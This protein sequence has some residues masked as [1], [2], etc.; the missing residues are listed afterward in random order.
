M[1]KNLVIGFGSD[2][3]S[4]RRII[5]KLIKDV[6]I[7][8]ADSVDFTCE[9]IN[10]LDLINLF[11][12]YNNLLIIDSV[13]NPDLEIGTMQYFSLENYQPGLHLENYHDSSL[14]ETIETAERLGFQVPGKIGIAIIN[15]KE[16]HTLST[17]FSNELNH[18]YP[19]LLQQLKILIN[20]FFLLNSKKLLVVD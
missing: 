2:I 17:S 3:I 15:V 11:E 10:N 9:L 14:I 7:I 13:Q 19:E 12:G 1:N 4:D 6:S 20:H 16:I 18:K 5:P 8:F